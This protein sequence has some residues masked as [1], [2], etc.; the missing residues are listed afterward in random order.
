MVLYEPQ[1]GDRTIG[2]FQLAASSTPAGTCKYRSQSASVSTYCSVVPAN[3]SRAQRT[4]VTMKR[5]T[6]CR[7]ESSMGRQA[8]SSSAGSATEPASSN[9]RKYSP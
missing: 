3:V 4:P 1:T 8:A 5:A 7:P 2:P 9:R 6:T